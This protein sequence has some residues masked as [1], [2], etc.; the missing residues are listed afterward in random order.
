MQMVLI[1]KAGELQRGVLAREGRIC[2]C[3]TRTYRMSQI[4]R[5]FFDPNK[6]IHVSV[7]NG[8]RY[9]R[10]IYV[11]FGDILTGVE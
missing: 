1:E 3:R 6:K 8:T 4:G 11:G 7:T 10:Y 5:Y 9:G 2:I